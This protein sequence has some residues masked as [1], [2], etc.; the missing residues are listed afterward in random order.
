VGQ[1]RYCRSRGFIL[2]AY[3]RHL[4]S[5]IRNRLF[6]RVVLAVKRVELVSN[7]MSYSAE[8]SLVLYCYFECACTN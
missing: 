2:F 8:R 1:R 5:S 4:K 3:K 6:F 7:R